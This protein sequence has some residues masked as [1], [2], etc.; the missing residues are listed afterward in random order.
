M[1]IIFFITLF[2]YLF[3]V[4][5]C[6]DYVDYDFFARLIVG[7][8]FF[9][10]GDI[11]KYDF[12]SYS[13]THPWWDH[14]W[15]SSIVFY[16]VQDHFQ[17]V[18]LQ[19][20]KAI[21]LFITFVFFVLII[22]LRRKNLTPD[23]EFP[24]FNF[25]FFFFALQP[26]SNPVF[27]L[28][29][30]HFTFMFFAI[31]L[32]VME[33]A[34]LEKNY[35]IMWVLPL[36]M[37]VWS[38]MHG[39][40]FMGLGITGLYIIGEFLRKKPFLPYIYLFIASFLVMFINPYGVE[41]VTFLVKATTMNRPNIVEWQPPFGSYFMAK[42]IKFK[43]VLLF[44][45][46]LSVYRFYKTWLQTKACGKLNKLKEIWNNMDKTK[47]VLVFVMFL[48]TMK[49]IRFISYFIFVLVP[50]CYDDFYSIFNKKLA[51]KY[52]KIKE[53]V[54][55]YIVLFVF[56]LNITV[57]DLRYG[58]FHSIFPLSEIEYLIENNVKGNV[59]VPFECGSYAAYK[60]YP[61][62]FILQ[63]GRY[64]EVY[65][66]YLNDEHVRLITLGGVGWKEALNSVHHDI[67]IP[68]KH[69]NL[70]EN[71]KHHPDYY[72]VLESRTFALF[73]RKEV[74]HRIKK[75]ARI[76]TDKPEFYKD[77][78]WNTQIDWLKK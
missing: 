47:A 33:K 66:P 65:S 21:C 67:I 32:Y 38:N 20:L 27:S 14:E 12:L 71:L 16:F 11:L 49:S 56:L 68:Y 41:Y 29:C 35:R 74:Y 30:H 45:M 62:N 10:T 61:N 63:D 59:F 24:I 4:G 44:F 48:L 75:P 19:V 3:L 43:I 58:N 72:L 73:I 31:W 17:D 57:R 39:G 78:L 34:R 64:E 76:P 2:L 1:L 26:I 52:N 6:M 15:G 69:Y 8:T 77:I 55:F 22:Q 23:K 42:F 54:L 5:S 36:L 7:K 50:F 40:C 46:G 18:G 25:L 53:L 37:I 28:R 60:L 70:Y 51:P 13:K 9:Q